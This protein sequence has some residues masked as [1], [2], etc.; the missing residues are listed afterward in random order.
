M[1]GVPETQRTLAP[2]FSP[3]PH[4]EIHMKQKLRMT[5]DQVGWEWGMV[6]VC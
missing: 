1:R 4:A 3:S 5:G 2:P 6:C